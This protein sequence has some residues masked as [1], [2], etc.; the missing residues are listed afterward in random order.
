MTETD[1]NVYAAAGLALRWAQ[2][3]EAE[4]VTVVLMHGV[5]RGAFRVR[6]EAEAFVRKSEK[7]PLRHLLNEAL[8]RVRF[9]PD[10]SGTFEAALDARN[11]F[12]HSFFWD[13]AE[14]FADDNQHEE[15]L[16]ELRELTQLLYSAHTFAVILRDLYAKQV[17]VAQENETPA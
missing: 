11:W 9:E 13:R 15:L 3:F 8:A 7:R 6:S 5:A 14:A 2:T 16:K 17:E 12:V 1:K 10:I 4:I